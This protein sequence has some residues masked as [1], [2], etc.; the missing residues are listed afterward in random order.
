MRLKLAAK[1]GGPVFVYP[2]T[3]DVDKVLWSLPAQ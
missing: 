1:A 3:A 2:W